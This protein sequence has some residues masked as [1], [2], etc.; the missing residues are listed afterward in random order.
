[1][2]L[3]PKQLDKQ[4]TELWAAHNTAWRDP[5]QV[6]TNWAEAGAVDPRMLRCTVSG[7]WWDALAQTGATLLITREY[8]HL[9]MALRV[10][11]GEPAVSYMAMPHPSGLAVNP[12]RCTVHIACTRNPNQVLDL[13]PAAGLMPRPDMDIDGGTLPDSPLVP[14]RSRFYPGCL[15]MHDLAFIGGE[16]HANSVGQNAVVRLLDHGQHERAWWPRCIETDSGPAFGQ[17]YI[18]L[19]SI[20]AGGN[21]ESSYFSASAE[22]LSARRPGHKNFPV[23][24]RGVIFSGATREPIARG[25]TRP[26]S[27]R[28]YNGQVW[29]DNSG[30][31]EFGFAENGG[32]TPVVRLP[33]WTRGLCFYKGI[34]FVGTSRVLPRFRQYAPGLDV[35]SS[36]CGIHAIDMQTGQVLGSLRWPYGNQIFAIEAAPFTTGFPLAGGAKRTANREKQLFY[37]FTTISSDS[38]ELHE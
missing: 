24:R 4:R 9:V 21:V 22:K 29:V 5:M 15:Y 30:Y 36:V 2:T 26:H 8:E 16:L 28:L 23:D 13:A 31:G 14:V 38:K 3:S 1:M 10:E 19:N 33:G 34:A 17:N 27:A 20:A 12:T 37:A 32:F 11:N 18:Q 6:I 7:T 35:D 25:L